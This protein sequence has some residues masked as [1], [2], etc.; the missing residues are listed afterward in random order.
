MNQ[1]SVGLHTSIQE[2]HVC[3]IMVCL[4]MLDMPS[5]SIKSIAYFCMLEEAAKPHWLVSIDS[6]PESLQS[7]V[8]DLRHH[9]GTSH[10]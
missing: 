2:A 6:R 9:K 3:D 1:M 8:R 4:P 5:C 10:W 7:P